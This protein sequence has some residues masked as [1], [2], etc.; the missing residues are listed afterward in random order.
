MSKL[1]ACII[2]SLA[3][4]LFSMVQVNAN[5]PQLNF[6]ALT[7][8]DGLSSNTVHTILKDRHGLLWFGTD[9]GLN[10]YD[11]TEFTVYRNDGANPA[12][13]A[14]N[15]ITS[16][17]EDKAGRIWVGTI[18]GALNLY[19]RKKDAF[20]RIC[21][22]ESVSAITSDP[23][24]K[25]WVGTIE[26]LVWVDPVT[27]K[28]TR[29]SQR[30]DVPAEIRNQLVLSL[31]KDHAG[32]M[33]VGTANGL[34]VYNFKTDRFRKISHAS[35]DHSQIKAL[36]GDRLG[37]IWVGTFNG[38]YK[39]AS[40]GKLLQ[41]YQYQADNEETISSNMIYAVAAEGPETILICTDGG[42]NV[43]NTGTG[44]VTR[45][46]PDARNPYS[47][48]NKSVRSILIDDRGIFWLGTYKGGVN[49]FDKNLTIFGL[50]NSDTY[51]PYGLTA[52][53]V[54]AFAEKE[55]GDLFVGTD[56]GGLNLYHRKTSLFTRV[57]L[58]PKNKLATSGLAVLSLEAARDKLWIGTFQD[59]LFQL[60]IATGRYQQFTWTADESSL[61]NNDIFCLKA[62]RTGKLWIGTNGGGVNVFD[63]QTQKFVRLFDER[64]PVAKR[65]IPLNGYIRDIL[66]DRNGNIWIGSHGTGLAIF[67]PE[68]NKSIHYDKLNSTLPGNNVL[69]LFEDS[70]GHIW[71]GTGGEGLAK[72]NPETRRFSIFG[73]K[74]GL[75]SG[76]INKILEDAQGRIW[77]STNQGLSYL[78]QTSK[79]F[80]NY[81]QHNGLQDNTFVLG[82]GIRTR[83]NQLFFGGIRGFNYLD[84]RLLRQNS[85]RIPVILK[86]L[87]VG[88]KSITPADSNILAEHISVA[89]SI[90]LDY[91]QNFTLTYAALNFSDATQTMYRHRLIGFDDEWHYAGLAKTAGYTNLNPG[92]YRFEVQAKNQNGTWNAPGTSLQIVVEPPFYMTVYAYIFYILILAGLVLL[93]RHR[94]I[95]KLKKK[96]RQEELETEAR[97]KRE[98]DEMKIKFLT[99]LSHE[100]RTPISLI[101]A[102]L[103]HLVNRGPE[104]ENTPHLQGIR[105]NAKRLLNL[106]DQLLD[107]KNLQQHES[108]LETTPG[109]IVS[110]VCETAESFR[111]LSQAKG[112]EFVVTH[113]IGSLEMDFDA[114]KVERIVL[115]LLSN[116]FKHTPR[117]GNVTLLMS[118]HAR[119]GWDRWLSIIISD[120]GVGIPADKLEKIFERFYQ[121]DSSTVLNQGSGIG[122]SIV[123]EFVQMHG[124]F[125]KVKSTPG[126]GST[127][128]VEL[129]CKNFNASA[130][131]EIIV[132]ASDADLLREPA[133]LTSPEIP[134]LLPDMPADIL[135]IEDDD[136]FRHY[137]KSNLEINYKII[138]AANGFEGWQKALAQHPQIIISDIAM[139]EMDGI[140]LSRKLKSDKRTAHIPVI[141]LTASTGEEH[142]LRGLSSGANDYLTKPFNFDILNAKIN[143]LLLLNR[144]LKS[145]YS[146][147]IDIIRP[148]P[149][150]VSGNQKLLKSILTYIDDNLTNSAE[151]GVEKMSKQLGMSRGTLYSKLL[152]MTGQTPIEFIKTI[153]LEKAALLAEKSDL[154]VS[155]ISYAA[156]FAS[157]N[158]FTKSFKAKFGM[159]PSEYI[160]SRRKPLPATSG[161]SALL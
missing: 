111:Y 108:Q 151:L 130:S 89:K 70:K 35:V 85:N 134:K 110:F 37:H 7:S 125:I 124:G 22:N 118:E 127:F 76:V 54:T 11:G 80:I 138:E 88:N 98:L 8:A 2:I 24:G 26:G 147:Q 150:I 159:L 74:Q 144:L 4:F 16:L 38:L 116:A 66:Q 84:T 113:E 143:N 96:F 1:Y 121:N 25:L 91:K 78:D 105:R 87:R 94:G 50:K 135:I 48:T 148:E 6:T 155:Q 142:E 32:Q 43:M 100:F 107:F 115:N 40:D 33:W 139:P 137:L 99:N 59:G 18:Q 49:K 83:D 156:G 81:T 104:A 154:N 56:G 102:P 126:E 5:G 103:D 10:K 149:E 73:Q 90:Q 31:Y 145:T 93:M 71:V 123:R 95:R 51:D 67:D 27:F 79:R 44:K 106:V 69:S 119:A 117:G 12:S 112:I 114:N 45:Y 52:P 132:P 63:P 160:Q 146:K 17:H 82:A 19:N 131:R 86:E 75:I 23:T 29:M 157:P 36:Y 68:Q 65:P 77:V 92:T 42:L 14:S 39:L 47:L 13:I 58:L 62:D 21:V 28:L 46:A 120:T 9:D 153:K 122:L 109:E 30:A 41:S 158:Y 136:E 55:N 34:F 97:R 128:T 72:Y 141:L 20:K 60:D 161:D 61:G 129:P 140:Q 15:D 101:L 133:A 53:F 57:P 64:T 3:A 152:E